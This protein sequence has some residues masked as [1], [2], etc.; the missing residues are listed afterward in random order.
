MPELPRAALEYDPR[1]MGSALHA[2]PLAC[3]GSGTVLPRFSKIFRRAPMQSRT[4]I[5]T[6]SASTA[7]AAFPAII[8][9][10]S[11]PPEM[12]A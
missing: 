11:A 2:V 8:P 7:C 4:V 5:W 12:W 10:R 3:R 9:M 1:D 6:A